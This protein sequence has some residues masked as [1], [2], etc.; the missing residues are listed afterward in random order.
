MSSRLPLPGVLARPVAAAFDTTMALTALPGR[1]LDLMSSAEQTVTTMNTAV[2]R[3][4][5]LL[6]RLAAVLAAAQQSISA[7]DAVV[8]HADGVA[9]RAEDVVRAADRVSADVATVTE[10]SGKLVTTAA[11][12]LERFDEPL[13]ELAPAAR[14]VTEAIDSC[15]TDALMTLIDRLPR[16]AAAVDDDIIPLLRRLDQVEPN[17]D[18]L[19]E[20]VSELNRT[21]R[22]LPGLRSAHEQPDKHGAGVA[23]GRE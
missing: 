1:V 15:E 13:R 6:E 9:G 11:P 7:A 21:V 12:L 5:E 22:R 4:E 17:L 2:A 16:L 18:Q 3:M 10:Q 8:T 23:P 19:L 14:R 20:L